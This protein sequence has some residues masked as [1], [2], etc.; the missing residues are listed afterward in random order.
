METILYNISQVIGVAIIHSMWQGLFIYLFLRL[1]L[2]SFS[3]M[4][5]KSKHNIA[6]LAMF[7]VTAWF[8]YTL[9]GEVRVYQ[10]VELKTNGNTGFIPAMLTMPLHMPHT[11]SFSSRY[12]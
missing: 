9:V 5:A 3:A 11:T 2:L 12:Y 6:M 4:S 10:W 7:G 1:V 8:L